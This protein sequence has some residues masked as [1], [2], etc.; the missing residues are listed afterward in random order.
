MNSN[1]EAKTERILEIDGRF[2][3]TK[4]KNKDFLLAAEYFKSHGMKDWYFPL[5][6]KDLGL[7][8]I[9]ENGSIKATAEEKNRIIEECKNNFWFYLREVHQI[10]L[11]VED[12]AKI[13]ALQEIR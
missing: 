7:I 3:D 9:I 10:S 1:V 12:I 5:E 6:I 2:Y 13:K 4:T 8:N 11:S